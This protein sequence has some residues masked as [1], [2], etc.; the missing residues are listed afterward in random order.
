MPYIPHFIGF[1]SQSLSPIGLF[2]VRL[3]RR[4]LHGHEPDQRAEPA[5]EKSITR[6]PFRQTARTLSQTSGDEK[7]RALLSRVQQFDGTKYTLKNTSTG[8]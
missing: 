2:K 3:D 5:D 4:Q 6:A 7:R 8:F 1:E